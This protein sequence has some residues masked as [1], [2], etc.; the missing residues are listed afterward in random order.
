M[1][2]PQKGSVLVIVIIGITI[3][4]AIGAGIAA[5]VSSG[6]RTGVNHSLS[7][8]AF[9]AAESG[10][11]WAEYTIRKENT[12]CNKTSLN[13]KKAN[14]G[15]QLTQADFSI[16]EASPDGDDC[17]VTVTGWV[18]SQNSPLAKR[19][20]T[21]KFPIDESG[22][23]NG[24]GNSGEENFSDFLIEENVFVYGSDL[25]F[26]GSNVFGD[27]ATIVIK[28]DLETSDINQGASIK[29]SNIYID[30]NVALDGGSASLGSSSEPGII[31]ING[32]LDLWSGGRNIYGDVYVNG[33]FR[34]KDARIHGNVY[35]NGDVELGWTPWLSNDSRIYYTGELNH[36]NYYQTSILEKCIQVSKITDAPGY[37]ENLEMPDYEIPG[38]RPDDWYADRGYASSG[39]LVD[40]L[41]IFADSYVS[42]TWRS[43]AENVVIVSKGDISITGL[44]GSG[45][46]GVLFAPYGK[47]TFN[48]GFFEGTVIARDGFF[49]TSGGTNITFRNIE[50]FFDEHEDIPISAD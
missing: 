12:D 1:I 37:D 39:I 8:Q 45:L 43:A 15:I 5:M 38:P 11:E 4:G 3:V 27:G 9:F 29:V 19:E 22:N 13:D 41:K 17:E 21:R 49:V 24:N 30:G 36:P 34:L 18:G 7:V 47:V 6:A 44:G 31:F 23:G 2:F 16:T 50:D 20:I 48:G 26:S 32:N 10:L 14:D 40:G 33:N 28:G 46:T 25:V 42:N 35:V